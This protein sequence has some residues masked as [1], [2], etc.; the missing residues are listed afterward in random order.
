[1]DT[2]PLVEHPAVSVPQKTPA[3]NLISQRQ[4]PGGLTRFGFILMFVGIAIGIIGG[5]LMPDGIIAAVGAL[6]AVAGIFFTA[7]PYL[8]PPRQQ[9]L[10][11]R[12]S[13]QPENLVQS[14]PEKYLPR[15]TNIEYVPSVTER[16]TALLE[17]PIPSGH[18][19]KKDKESDA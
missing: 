12:P 18:K 11:A 4:R 6:I 16:T 15:E 9:K 3:S 2:R 10:D 19:Q 8:S 17:N 7:Y 14:Q 5:K 1:M 13:S